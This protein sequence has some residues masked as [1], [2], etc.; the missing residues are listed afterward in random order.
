MTSSFAPSRVIRPS[1]PQ[2]RWMLPA[3]ATFVVL[4]AATRV[5]AQVFAP[6]NVV[7]ADRGRIIEY[8]PAGVAVRTVP[9]PS[10]AGA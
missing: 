1:F 3:A 8:T 6:G 5:D 2:V 9:L 10:G 4:A 7:V